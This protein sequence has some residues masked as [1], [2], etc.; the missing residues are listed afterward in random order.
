MINKGNKHLF[1][2][3]LFFNCNKY[4]HI[5]KSLDTDLMH[6]IILQIQKFNTFISINSTIFFQKYAEVSK[7]KTNKI[8]LLAIHLENRPVS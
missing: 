4:L 5:Y 8:S 6:I 1:L 2:L 3:K 7:V